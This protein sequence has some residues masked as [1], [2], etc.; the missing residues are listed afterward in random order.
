[1]S[2][3]RSRLQPKL[4]LIEKAGGIK[5]TNMKALSP[6]ERHKATWSWWALLF[7][8]FYY[9]YHGVWKKGIVLF[10]TVMTV[11]ILGDIAVQM[12][13]PSMYFT[14]S[15]VSSFMVPILFAGCAPRNLYSKYVL[16]ENGWNPFY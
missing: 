16:N 10:A 9:G 7:T 13:I 3:K 5:F 12:F 4:D 8:I 11:V 15:T 2:D 6:M 14:W 1:M